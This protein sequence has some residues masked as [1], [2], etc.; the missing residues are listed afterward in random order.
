MRRP[1]WIA[2][3]TFA[4]LLVTT[5]V[6]SAIASHAEPET[7]SSGVALYHGLAMTSVFALATA[8]CSLLIR[9]GW[10]TLAVLTATGAALGPFTLLTPPWSSSLP[11]SVAGAPAAPLFAQAIVA[12]VVIAWIIATAAII[13]PA[14]LSQRLPY[15]TLAFG[16][17]LA[18]VVLVLFSWPNGL[19]DP[20]HGDLSMRMVLGWALLSAGIV[21]A[22]IATARRVGDRRST[23][24]VL[25]LPILAILVVF[26]LYAGYRYD[27]GWPQVAGWAYAQ[28]PIYAT[29]ATS[30]VL[31]ISTFVAA[32]ALAA[33]GHLHPKPESESHDDAKTIRVGV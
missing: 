10:Q 7:G 13:S 18:I 6:A 1:L 20:G 33:R 27:G 11:T 30:V 12:F 28:A 5:G 8:T 19:T 22:G 29:V 24:I 17:P 4:F 32:V 21:A 3:S 2:I 31:V 26:A 25:A 23:S 15:S 14:T 9:A 16:G